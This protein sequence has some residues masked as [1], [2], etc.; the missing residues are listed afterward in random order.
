[1]PHPL[2]DETVFAKFVI[3][4]ENTEKRTDVLMLHA[5][6]HH[7]FSHCLSNDDIIN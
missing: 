1:M 7:N 5:T 4:S 3:G 2:H 6:K